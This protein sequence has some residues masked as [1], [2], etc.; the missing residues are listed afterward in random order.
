MPEDP[1]LRDLLGDLVQVN[2]RLVRLAARRL[3]HTRAGAESPAVWRTLGVLVVEGPMRLGELAAR[4]RVAQ[5]TMTKLVATMAERGHVRRQPDPSDA[6]ALRITLTDAG[7]AAYDGWRT[8]VAAALAP[9]F[10]GLAP[11]DVAAL[12]RTVE[13]LRAR[14]VAGEADDQPR[15]ATHREAS[16]P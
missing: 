14:T 5:P 16:R 10:T 4:S 1:E 9:S 8:A 13:I 15:A 12:R 11:E 7:R 2:G 6:R 3:V